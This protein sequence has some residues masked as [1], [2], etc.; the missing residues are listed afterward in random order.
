M[1]VYIENKPKGNIQQN[2]KNKIKVFNKARQKVI[3]APREDCTICTRLYI[4]KQRGHF[5]TRTNGDRKQNIKSDA[6][7]RK[8]S[9][10]KQTKPRAS[11]AKGKWRRTG[12]IC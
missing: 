6:A 2:G 4:P 8:S 10:I 5:L 9:K 11:V 3:L 1:I 7:S 12:S